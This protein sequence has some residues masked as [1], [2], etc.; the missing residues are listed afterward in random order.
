[1]PSCAIENRGCAIPGIA[2]VSATQALAY[3]K[4]TPGDECSSLGE[5]GP[6]AIGE[7]M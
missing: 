5:Y 2:F 7:V 6:F 3:S 4:S 1:M